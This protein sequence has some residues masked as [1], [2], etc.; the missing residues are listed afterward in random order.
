MKYFE[1]TDKYLRLE[2]LIYLIV[3]L[4]IL[5]TPFVMRLYEYVTDE[6]T[7]EYDWNIPFRGLCFMFPFVLIF[8]INDLVLLPLLF[9]RERKIIYFSV[10]PL[11]CILVWCIS[12]PP[13]NI[14]PE[15]QPPVEALA[16]DAFVPGE[17]EMARDRG[18]DPNRW[19]NI[20]PDIDMDMNNGNFRPM[21]MRL[22]RMINFVA[23]MNELALIGILL[24][25]MALKLYMQTLRN[26]DRLEQSKMEQVKSE[27]KSLKYQVNP[28]FL[29]NTLNNIQA[30]IDID[31]DRAQ[32]VIQQ[33]SKMMRYMLYESDRNMVPLSKEI[34]FMQHFVDLMRIR[35]PEDVCIM[36]S[37]P[38]VEKSIYIHSLLFISFVE[39]AFKYGVS[40]DE[41]SV[42]SVS[43]NVEDSLLKFNCINTVN[44]HPTDEGKGGIG[45]QNARKR[46]DLLYPGEYSLNISTAD[47]LYS[48]SLSIPYTTLS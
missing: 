32:V 38:K 11:F 3:G 35:Y 4:V 42:V 30:L 17:R 6:Y 33:L 27:L 46:L 19:E 43:L 28:H 45:L 18:L 36:T 24:A 37:F 21:P 5:M 1:S 13:R 41:D 12:E 16:D 2:R 29:M 20:R 44:Q 40:Y 34:E 31:S 47:N 10:I 25:N 26:A 15:N 8:L 14:R 9:L 23:V 7:Q 22:P 48:V 39:N